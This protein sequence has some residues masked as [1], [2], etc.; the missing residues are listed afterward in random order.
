MNLE[1]FRQNLSVVSLAS[2]SGGNAT[3][4][5]TDDS[6]VL[7]DCGISCKQVR[8]RM[9]AAGLHADRL[10]A[11]LVT[12]EHSDHVAGVRVCAQRLGVPVYMTESCARVVGLP[13]NVEVRLFEPG[14]SFMVGTVEVQPYRIPH[15]TVDPVG[16]VLGCGEDRVGICTDLG[17]VTALVIDKLRACRVV[18][19]E[20][21]HDVEM[22]LE[23]P[24][25]WHL[26]QRVRSRHG[27][28][29]NDQ[30][31]QL[32]QS[33]GDGLVEVVLLAHLSEKNN[34]PDLALRAARKAVSQGH[35]RPV[36]LELLTQTGPGP[37]IPVR[38]GVNCIESSG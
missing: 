16:F 9:A 25:P 31:A 35:S 11:I 22:L 38:A 37:L 27:H 14:V 10:S 15:D 20:F 26:K 30:A 8:L 1:L 19:L 4:V 13:D 3:V 5:S 18:L 33:L 2:G 17:S 6:A 36:R 34:H 32:L 12:H 21:N 29:S 28:L 24:Y 23:G 7:V